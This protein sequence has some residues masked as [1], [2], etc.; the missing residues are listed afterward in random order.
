MRRD[1]YIKYPFYG[2]LLLDKKEVIF[3]LEA[4]K[5]EHNVF[6]YGCGLATNFFSAY[7]NKWYSVEH[8]PAW[9]EKIKAN[10]HNN[11]T[12]FTEPLKDGKK[13]R[14]AEDKSSDWNDVL[15]SEYAK[16][17]DGYIKTFSSVKDIDIVFIDG[18]ARTAC[19]KYVYDNMK[20]DCKIIFHDWS[21]SWYRCLDSFRVV[22]E[23]SPNEFGHRDPHIAILEKKKNETLL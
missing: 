10:K 17:Y 23:L 11:T 5:R 12:I 7:V 15:G 3:V 13:A 8:D 1:R 14:F 22:K 4:I 2:S 19:A 9:A 20:D 21:R 18:R 16:R 6:E